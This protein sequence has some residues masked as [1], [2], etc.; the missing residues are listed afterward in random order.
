MG[1]F[2]PWVGA[3]IT[4]LQ[5]PIVFITE[6]GRE[7]EVVTRLARV[8]YDNTLGFLEGGIDAWKAAGKELDT[9]DSLTAEEFAQLLEKGLVDNVIDVRKPTEYITQHIVGAKNFPA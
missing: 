2:A 7:E 5:Q 1:D 3:L 6:A 8:G 4:D 9:I